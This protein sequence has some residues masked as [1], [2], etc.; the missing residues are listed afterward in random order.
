MDFIRNAKV[1][2]IPLK[3]EEYYKGQFTLKVWDY[4]QAKCIV[5]AHNTR[6]MNTLPNFIEVEEPIEFDS[7]E[8]NDFDWT[9]YEEYNWDRVIPKIMKKYGV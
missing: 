2:L 9:K 8:W 7:L 6:N 1:G 4:L 3:D 5:V